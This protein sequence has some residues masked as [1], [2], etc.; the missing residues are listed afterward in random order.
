MADAVKL[1]VGPADRGRPMS[2]EEFYEADSQE[3][4]VYELAKGVL[5][6]VDV[7][8][9][10]HAYVLQRLDMF[11]F[12]FMSL[13]P[14]VIHLYA[15]EARLQMPGML[16]DRHPD[17]AIYLTAP[18]DKERWLDWVPDIAIEVVSPGG[19]SRE[20][21]LQTKR[22]EYLAAGVR[23]YWVIDPDAEEVLVLRR[24]GDTWRE[25]RAKASDRVTT[26]LLPGFDLAVRE[27]FVRPNDA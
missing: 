11:A 17:R 20:R 14:G 21:D 22:E 15:T 13:R 1:R 9:I 12:A 10:P 7:P 24:A 3:G 23:E 25:R 26:R 2:L 5:E 4:Y 6:V 19:E 27:L 16:S 18:P 8:R